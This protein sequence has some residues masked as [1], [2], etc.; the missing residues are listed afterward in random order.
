MARLPLLLGHRGARVSSEIPENTFAS[1]DLALDHGC[2]GFEFDVRRTACGTAVVCHDPKVGKLAIARSQATQLRELPRLTDVIE[3]YGGRG[4]LNVELKVK[5]LESNVLTAL[6][7]FPPQRGYV[8]SSFIPDVVMELEARSS[9]V[10]LGIICETPAQLA[11]WRKLPVDCVIPEQS[12]VDR[13]LVLD[14]QRAGL[15][16]F[17]WTVND[18]EAMRRLAAWGVDGIISDETKLLVGTLR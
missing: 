6:G 8:V 11:G 15:R 12:L 17:V 3:Q 10:T 16:I 5:D 7:Q 4:F 2:D 9:S 18:P 14:V 1:F 13:S